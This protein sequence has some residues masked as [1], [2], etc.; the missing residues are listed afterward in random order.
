LFLSTAGL[1]LAYSG[2][3]LSSS[4]KKKSLA[5][6]RERQLGMTKEKTTENDLK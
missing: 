4:K 1:L 2:P 3:G 5:K 6:R